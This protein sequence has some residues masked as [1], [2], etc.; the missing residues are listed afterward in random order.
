MKVIAAAGYRAAVTTLPARCCM[1]QLLSFSLKSNVPLALG[2]GARYRDE[3]R[4]WPNDRFAD[5]LSIGGRFFLA[6]EN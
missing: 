5:W 3:P 6:F 4:V 2:L 1:G